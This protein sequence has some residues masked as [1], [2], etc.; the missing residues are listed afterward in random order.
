MFDS[1]SILDKL[2]TEKRLMVLDAMLVS[3]HCPGEYIF[4]AG[5]V[6]QAMFFIAKGKVDVFLHGKQVATLDKGAYFG[7]IALLTSCPRNADVMAHSGCTEAVEL[8]SLTRSTLSE[9][10]SG[11]K[12]LQQDLFSMAK[13]RE[14][15]LASKTDAEKEK[16]KKMVERIDIFRPLA[17]EP[18]KMLTQWLS[19]ESYEPGDKICTQGDPGDDVKFIVQGVVTVMIEDQLLA[20]LCQG[21]FFGEISLITRAP[22]TADCIADSTVDVLSLSSKDY[23][24]LQLRHFA[25]KNVTHSSLRKTLASMPQKGEDNNGIREV[26]KVIAATSDSRH[27]DVVQHKKMQCF[28]MLD[29]MSIFDRLDTAGRLKVLD[30]MIV[31]YFQPG[32]TIFQA[33]EATVFH[34]EEV[35]SD[36]NIDSDKADTMVVLA[37]KKEAKMYFIVKGKVDVVLQGQRVAT[38]EAGSHFGEV[39]MLTNSVRNAD[40]VAHIHTLEE[41]VALEHE[42]ESAVA[43]GEIEEIDASQDNGLK[44]DGG[45]ENGLTAVELLCL[46]RSTLIELISS[47]VSMQEDIFHNAKQKER[48]VLAGEKQELEPLLN[49]VELFK[50]LPAGAKHLL[51]QWLHVEKYKAGEG[52]HIHI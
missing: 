16:L 45:L 19:L 18:K 31:E 52:M 32:T 24:Q 23:M 46:T 51:H 6:G 35:E 48:V 41:L 26:L 28:P 7:E 36:S 21:D 38:L 9:L 50:G 4:R 42:R 11:D 3:Y 17:P 44:R 25:L 2:D 49:R 27:K 5:D 12:K 30:S 37:P 1:V 33:G 29:R 8:L 39:S 34:E 43:N 22:R 20:T 14:Q 47:D 13:E 40:L 10:I 15:T